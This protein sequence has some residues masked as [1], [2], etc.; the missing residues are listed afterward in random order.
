MRLT[1]NF[2][3]PG[4]AYPT[5]EREFLFTSSAG[6]S[7]FY[8]DGVE[9]F[10][11]LSAA[12]IGAGGTPTTFGRQFG[13]YGEYFRGSIDA[14]RIYD[15]VILPGDVVE[16]IPEPASWALLIT[17]FGLTGAALRRRRGAAVA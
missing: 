13:G 14:I 3:F 10:S 2:L 4:I 15:A 11:T 1:D 8:I 16:G 17:G 5:G 12:T 7:K 6:G 9:T